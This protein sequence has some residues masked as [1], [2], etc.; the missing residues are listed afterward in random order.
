MRVVLLLYLPLLVL[1]LLDV[2]LVRVEGPSLFLLK[3]FKFELKTL[4]FG[5]FHGLSDVGVLVD[6]GL[7]LTFKFIFEISLGLTKLVLGILLHLQLLPFLLL[8]QLLP[9]DSDLPIDL[10]LDLRAYL[11]FLLS[12]VDLPPLLLLLDLRLVG[13]E[14]LLLLQ[15]EVLVDLFNGASEVLLE[16]LS[17]LF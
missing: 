15:F 17:L 1:E 16:Q 7:L 6:E 8:L 5:L 11:L 2:I 14:D 4:F 9:V 12:L 10:H 13:L 3:F